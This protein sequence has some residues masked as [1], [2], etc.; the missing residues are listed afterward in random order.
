[1]FDN[2]PTWAL[3][4]GLVVSLLIIAGVV[5]RALYAAT[6]YMVKRMQDKGEIPE[7]DRMKA[8]EA[9]VD[10]TAA[11]V[12][13]TRTVVFELEHTVTN[14]LSTKVEASR[15]WQ[16]EYGSKIDQLIGAVNEHLRQSRG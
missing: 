8:L 10:A 12:E 5:Y 1:M 3:W 4:A 13:Q 11:T 9:K 6:V 7:M 15:K 16:R 14:G 2:L